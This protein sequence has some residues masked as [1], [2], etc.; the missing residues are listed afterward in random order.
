MVKWMALSTIRF[1]TPFD[2][3]WVEDCREAAPLKN[4]RATETHRDLSDA[5]FPENPQC[6]EAADRFF[7]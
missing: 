6:E 5:S 3:S 1:F 4:R 2:R 7:R